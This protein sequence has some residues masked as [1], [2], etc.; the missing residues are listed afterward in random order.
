MVVVYGGGEGEQAGQLGVLNV[1]SGKWTSWIPAMLNTQSL[2]TPRTGAG[3]VSNFVPPDHTLPTWFDMILFGGQTKDSTGVSDS[4]DIWILRQFTDSTDF[5]PGASRSVGAVTCPAS[6]IT[7]AS[8][9]GTGTG[10]ANQTNKKITMPMSTF[11]LVHALMMGSSFGVIIPVGVIVKRYVT[12]WKRPVSFG[13]AVSQVIGMFLAI[14]G[15]IFATLMVE[16]FSRDNHFSFAHAWVGLFAVMGGLFQMFNGFFRALRS[17]LIDPGITTLHDQQ[18]RPII[19]PESHEDFG[20]SNATPTVSDINI[21]WGSDTGG[22]T[23]STRHNSIDGISSRSSFQHSTSA[24]SNITTKP[25]SDTPWSFS[26]VGFEDIPPVAGSSTITI[27]GIPQHNDTPPPRTSRWVLIHNG[28]GYI[29]VLLGM[30]NVGL[31]LNK[32][33]TYR[34]MFLVPYIVWGVALGVLVLTMEIRRWRRRNGAAFLGGVVRKWSAWVARNGVGKDAVISCE[35]GQVDGAGNAK[36][37]ADVTM[38]QVVVEDGEGEFCTIAK[39]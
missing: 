10:N 14:V 13:H 27:A 35:G 1:M 18:T 38:R 31:G 19:R 16:N 22:D 20:S 9:N 30:I 26:D 21:R 39:G 24:P 23:A 7:G 5:G 34:D 2:P 3:M 36:M 37:G 29:V 8:G 28:I 12:R 17:L 4:N 6:Q 11:L 32:S 25:F 33:N 15:F